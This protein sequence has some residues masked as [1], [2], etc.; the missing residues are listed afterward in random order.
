MRNERDGVLIRVTLLVGSAA[1]A[2]TAI[3]RVVT[4]HIPLVSGPLAVMLL[5]L[6]CV[7]PRDRR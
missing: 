7:W 2:V 6:A 3:V 4:G 1:L 5:A